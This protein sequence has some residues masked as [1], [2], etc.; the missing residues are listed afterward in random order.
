MAIDT[1]KTN[2][3]Q[4]LRQAVVQCARE[5]QWELHRAF[6]QAGCT[7]TPLR[8]QLDKADAECQRQEEELRRLHPIFEMR[9][10]LRQEIAEVDGREHPALNYQSRVASPFFRVWL[11]ECL[12]GESPPDIAHP[13]D[14]AAAYARAWFDGW[15]PKGG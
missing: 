8:A 3:R 14:L 10:R 15:R 7:C 12:V 4:L 2:K 1:I 9:E 13:K 11:F 5:V 6:E